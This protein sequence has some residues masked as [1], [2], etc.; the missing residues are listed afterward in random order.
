MPKKP[1]RSNRSADLGQLTVG[2]QAEI[3]KLQDFADR[4]IHTLVLGP[5]G[6]GKSHSAEAAP[7]RELI[8]LR[9]LKPQRQAIL[10]LAEALYERG[11]LKG[12]STPAPKDFGSFKRQ[13][14][15]IGV[16][17]WVRVVVE[18][19]AKDEWTLVIDDL[20][21]LTLPPVKFSIGCDRPRRDETGWATIAQQGEGAYIGSPASGPRSA[22]AWC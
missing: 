4:G 1:R 11:A 18:A 14:S 7:G 3:Q 15:G 8:R 12:T 19:V 16:Q 6:V 2:R 22:L 10:I 21:D 9:G 5:P 20:S 17:G 13:Y